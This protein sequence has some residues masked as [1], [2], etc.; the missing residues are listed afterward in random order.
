MA[1]GRADRVES[2]SA[3]SAFL[4]FISISFSRATRSLSYFHLTSVIFSPNCAWTH[5]F[6]FDTHEQMR[7][8][9]GGEEASSTGAAMDARASAVLTLRGKSGSDDASAGGGGGVPATTSIRLSEED[10]LKLQNSMDEMATRVKEVM[11]KYGEGEKGG[12]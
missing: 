11:D 3:K 8:N 9:A 10:C 1:R 12:E 5:L 7:E 2:A 4:L 6:L